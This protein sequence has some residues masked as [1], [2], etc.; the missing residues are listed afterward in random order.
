[1]ITSLKVLK[2]YEIIRINM[3]LLLSRSL[4]SAKSG[5]FWMIL[6]SFLFKSTL[7][8]LMKEFELNKWKPFWILITLI[9]KNSLTWPSWSL[10]KVWNGIIAIASTKNLDLM[11]LLAISVMSL[12]LLYWSSGLNSRRNSKKGIIYGK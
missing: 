5:S 4:F 3:I 2:K 9:I 1:M 8:Y 11:Y 7:T 12:T 10:K 6:S